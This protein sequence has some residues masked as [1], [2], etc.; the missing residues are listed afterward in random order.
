MARKFTDADALLHDLLDRHERGVEAPVAYPDHDAFSTVIAA[1]AFAKAISTAGSAN[2]VTLV[3]GTGARR[4]ELK[5]IRLAD[6][7]ALYEYLRREPSRCI[8]ENARTMLLENS[9]IHPAIQ[10]AVHAAAEAWSRNRRWCQLG[11][12]DTDAVRMAIQLAN[13][14]IERKH[15]GIDYRTFSRKITGDSKALER[16]ETAVVKL[17]GAAIEL[18]PAPSPR[19]TL[20]ALGLE[21]FSLPLLLA[22]ALTFDGLALP[23]AMPYLGAPPNEIARIDF[24]RMPAYVL[25]IENFTSFNRHVLEA[26]QNR[27]GLTI[28]VGGYPSLAAQRALS[29]LDSALPKHIPFFHWSDIDPDGTWIFRTVERS[30]GR[31]LVPHLMTRELAKLYGRKPAHASVLR[32]GTAEGSMISDLMD[33]FAEDGFKVMEQEEIDPA[34]PDTP[35]RNHT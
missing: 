20:E 31:P 22:G 17:I 7:N 30:I 23:V 33:Y 12:E 13:A 27:I 21:R 14:V 24:S 1:D 4:G 3:Y 29:A 10:E 11:P 8:A 15:D 9:K 35:V 32:R 26:D 25:T 16:L 28:Y 2:C 34:L 5:L 19:A 6:A 18:P